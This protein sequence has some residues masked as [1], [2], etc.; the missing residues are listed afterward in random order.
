MFDMMI[1]TDAVELNRAM[2]SLAATLAA[3]VAV[4]AAPVYDERMSSERLVRF[5]ASYGLVVDHLRDVPPRRLNRH[6]RG[7]MILR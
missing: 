6:G 3:V 7:S 5:H 1:G 2:I 4:R